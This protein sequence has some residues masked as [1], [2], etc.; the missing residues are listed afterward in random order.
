MESQIQQLL[1]DN[2]LTTSQKL[3]QIQQLLP[4][5]TADAGADEMLIFDQEGM[6]SQH[7]V[8]PDQDH[9]PLNGWLR[10]E[11]RFRFA[12]PCAD[13]E[14]ILN[15]EFVEYYP[16]ETP[17]YRAIYE[18]GELTK[19]W[20]YY[21]SG[22]VRL[23]CQ[24]IHG[25]LDRENMFLDADRFYE[26][27]CPIKTVTTGHHDQDGCG[28]IGEYFYPNFD[29][30][31]TPI[32]QRAQ[33]TRHGVPHGY[34]RE[35]H[36]NGSSKI[37]GTYFNGKCDGQW[38]QWFSNGQPQYYREWDQGVLRRELRWN[39]AGF[40][41]DRLAPKRKSTYDRCGCLVETAEK[42]EDNNGWDIVRYQHNTRVA[43]KFHETPNGQRFQLMEVANSFEPGHPSAQE[44]IV[45]YQQNLPEYAKWYFK[46]DYRFNRGVKQG[47]RMIV[48]DKYTSR[49][50]KMLEIAQ[51]YFVGYFV[52]FLRIGDV[53]KL[54]VIIPKNL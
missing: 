43:S 1:N 53:Y 36:D 31:S 30:D 12:G 11:Y 46:W 19:S 37:I 42:R 52:R 51:K 45:N 22:R 38:R 49:K 3:A 33:D 23:E 29:P 26:K 8:T 9:H 21:P 7:W 2:E 28:F 27:Q 40:L 25:I 18:N 20:Y 35:D 17:M 10:R 48:I 6:L 32:V 14:R 24:Y 34:Y 54:L 13:S 47:K 4:G 44:L 50:E 15:G 39:G 5:P 16:T 41:T